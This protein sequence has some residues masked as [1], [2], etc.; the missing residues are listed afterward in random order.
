MGGNIRAC[1]KQLEDGT[2]TTL[3]EFPDKVIFSSRFLE[4]GTIIV[5]INFLLCLEKLILSYFCLPLER[6]IAN[7]KNFILVFSTFCLC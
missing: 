2:A 5:Y 7:T 3:N 4:Y 6:K 1:H